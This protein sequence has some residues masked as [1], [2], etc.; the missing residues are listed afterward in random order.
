MYYLQWLGQASEVISATG[1]EVRT[2]IAD[3]TARSSR[4]KLR[5]TLGTL[6]ISDS[7][8]SD[9]NRTKYWPALVSKINSYVYGLPHRPVS[10]KICISKKDLIS[11][12][13]D[14]SDLIH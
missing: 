11:A 12:M 14:M 2:R 1:K 5:M 3:L 4:V 6:I 9:L 10:V 7:G 8:G 13:S